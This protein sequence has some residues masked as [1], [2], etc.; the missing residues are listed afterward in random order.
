MSQVLRKWIADGA[1]NNS[2]IDPTDTYVVS[3]LDAT[4]IQAVDGTFSHLSIGILNQD[5]TVAGVLT[6]EGL[7]VADQTSGYQKSLLS[8]DQMSFGEFEGGAY[9]GRVGI[10]ENQWIVNTVPVWVSRAPTQDWGSQNALAVSSNGQRMLASVNAGLL[11]DSSDFGQT[12]VSNVAL[13]GQWD[14]VAMSADGKFQAAHDTN[15]GKIYGSDNYGLTW[16]LRITLNNS[17]FGIALSADGRYQLVGTS[18]VTN[19]GVAVSRDHGMTWR[20]STHGV[21]EVSDVAMSSDGQIQAYVT[22]GGHVYISKNYGATWVPV[23]S[24]GKVLYT[25]S[26]SDDGKYLLA[27]GLQDD[28]IN[29]DTLYTSN[30]YGATW[31]T[32]PS[33]IWLSSVIS[34]NGK[35]QLAGQTNGGVSVSYDYGATW[36]DSGLPTGMNWSGAGMSSDGKIL[37]VCNQ[38]SGHIYTSY[39]DSSVVGNVGVNG[40]LT[41]QD[42]LTVVGDSTVQGNLKVGGDISFSGLTDTTI[43]GN[44]LVT[45]DSTF[46]GGVKIDGLLTT[47]SD[48]TIGNNLKVL[49]MES[50][51]GGL[52]VSLDETVS[53]NFQVLGDSSVKNLVASGVIVSGD[54]TVFGGLKVFG[55]I[56]M[57]GLGDTTVTGNLLVTGKSITD[58]DSTVGGGLS[59][60]GITHSSDTT[61]YGNLLV[62]GKTVT[63][64]D[65]TVQGGL[66][67]SGTT[68]SSDTSVSGNLYVSNDST[69]GRNLDVIGL[70]SITG[71]ASVYGNIIGTN[72]TN[73]SIGH[74]IVAYGNIS[75]GYVNAF[76]GQVSQ[77]ESIV[78]KGDTAPSLSASEVYNGIIKGSPT[79]NRNYTLPSA[80]SL[81]ALIPNAVVGTAIKLIIKNTAAA[82]TTTGAT[83]TITVVASTITNGGLARDFTINA[84]TNAM[85]DIV[86]T[87]V[88]PSSESA[89]M[90]RNN[91]AVDDIVLSGSFQL[92]FENKSIFTAPISITCFYKKVISSATGSPAIVTLNVP[93]IYSATSNSVSFA[94]DNLT[95][96]S[97]LTPND[98]ISVPIT[99]IDNGNDVAGNVYTGGGY[100]IFGLLKTTDSVSH[101]NPGAGSYIKSD[102]WTASGNKG[103]Y[104]FTITY[105]IWP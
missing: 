89:V 39:S 45:N 74:N 57:S 104:E 30:N 23:L 35:I 37:A 41:V 52:S 65:A 67:V 17:G 92:I 60:S 83:N 70:A 47:G 21:E 91:G 32:G 82:T 81:L 95:L 96:P 16:T 6:V 101:L 54:A 105:P 34:S 1:I 25:V 50:I 14:G 49:G 58:G 88:T 87:N 11:Y 69:V 2:K 7:T 78:D 77:F 51:A 66:S 31:S 73:I 4:V 5:M 24:T 38:G 90:Y 28:F 55:D 53:R 80:A 61:V 79:V 56:S 99:V 103:F 13:T 12:W 48:A 85:Y 36:S 100:L 40:N 72:T 102:Q 15:T 42:L 97:V 75:T 10:T 71:D 94:S 26:M 98:A 19:A 64:G 59:V 44:L 93:G 22:E 68:H 76:G 33:A 29:P 62:T 43:D 84:S 63:D 8:T 9:F 86:F 46:E 3:G 27:G 18:S 20:D